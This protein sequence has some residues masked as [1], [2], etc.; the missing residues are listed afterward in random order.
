MAELE[1]KTQV[2]SSKDSMLN[3][4]TTYT[5]FLKRFKK[6]YFVFIVTTIFY[7]KDNI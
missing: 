4:Y 3:H 7:C 2:S 1:I 6:F 5:V